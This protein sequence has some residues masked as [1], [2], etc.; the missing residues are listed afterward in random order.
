[1]NNNNRNISLDVLR[2]IACFLVVFYHCR[3]VNTSPIAFSNPI[4]IINGISTFIAFVL[5]RL[6]VPLFLLIGGYFAFSNQINTFT[7]LRKRLARIVIPSAFWLVFNT[8]LISG[9]S[10]FIHNIWNLTCA[11]HLWYIYTLI[12]ILFLIP[13]VNPFLQQASNKELSIYLCIWGLSLIFNG[14]NFKALSVYSLTNYGMCTPNIVLSFINFYGFFGYYVCGFMLKRHSMNKYMIMCFVV[15]SMFIWGI[16]TFFHGISVSNLYSNW[17]YLSIPVVLISVSIFSIVSNFNVR[18]GGGK[19]RIVSYFT[20]GI[21]LVHW[22]IIDKLSQMAFFQNANVF[23]T[24]AV[25]L[26]FRFV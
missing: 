11:G 25:V 4:S 20:F 13:V 9:T 3:T 5:G 18:Y 26:V 21:Y 6:G 22:L 1:M 17:L 2:I 19:I 16:S 15:L 14:N 24:T 8:L 7:F 10:N 23:I 12:G